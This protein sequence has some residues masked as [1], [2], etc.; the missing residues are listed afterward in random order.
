MNHHSRGKGSVG[1]TRY[2]VAEPPLRTG[3]MGRSSEMARWPRRR[4]AW[5]PQPSLYS[6]IDASASSA[7]TK[8]PFQTWDLPCSIRRIFHT[9]DNLASIAPRPVGS[10]I[11]S[12]RSGSDRRTCPRTWLPLIS[13]AW[14]VS[15]GGHYGPR[16]SQDAVQYETRCPRAI[17]H[18]APVL[19]AG[20][21][22]ALT[23]R[24]RA[25]GR[26]RRITWTDLLVSP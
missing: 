3:T 25:D 20:V 24:H 4:I 5:N 13:S 10:P 8:L 2:W 15:I 12:Y 26:W 1:S 9:P 6:R 22:L 7:L 21:A 19:T 14:S 18:E 11:T 17:P 23:G 16:V